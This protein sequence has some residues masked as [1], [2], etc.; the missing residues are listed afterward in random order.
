MAT[1][2]K[3]DNGS[4]RVVVEL[5]RGPDGTRRRQYFDGKT[6]ELA[7]AKMAA[8]FPDP[9]MPKGVTAD[10]W[11]QLWD[12]VAGHAEAKQVTDS[13]VTE[14]TFDW[15]SEPVGLL[16]WSDWHIGST[17]C[18]YKQLKE[19]VAYVAAYRS[20]NPGALHLAH[21]GDLVDNY[22]ASG[23]HPTGLH[24]TVETRTDKQ[25]GLALW[26]AKQAG[27][28]D[29]MLLGCHLAWNLTHEGDDVLA[30]IAQQLG[31]VNGGYGLNMTIN[32]GS[33]QYTGLIRHKPKG[34]GGMAPGN[35]QRRLDNEYGPAGDRADFI[36]TSHQHTCHLEQYEKAG[37]HVVFTRSG[38]YK[39][40]DC[41]AR[42]GAFTHEKSSDNGVPL[43]IFSPTT[44]DIQA[45][46]GHH[47]RQGLEYLASLRTEKA[48]A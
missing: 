2:Y 4:W 16:L 31:A 3:R 19:D 8:A 27:Q 14:A 46:D 24:E 6:E 25:R 11:S 40:G 38:G 22:R 1:A 12:A 13:D 44:H 29:A 20:A 7:R 34:G 42:A 10:N 33:Q 48:A 41:F 32:V 28:W 37:R 30:P 9:I 45:F 5:E 43:L 23:P 17:W 15:G 39:G 21:L 47:W 36:S 26:L 35:A 18:D